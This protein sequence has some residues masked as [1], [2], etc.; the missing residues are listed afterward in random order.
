MIRLQFWRLWSIPS[1]QLF[2]LLLWPE[3]VIVYGSKQR[4]IGLCAKKKLLRNNYTKNVNMNVQRT[5]FIVA[6][7]VSM[8]RP[9]ACSICSIFPL[10]VE[11]NTLKKS[12]NKS[13]VSRFLHEFLV[14]IDGLSESVMFWISFSTSYFDSF[15]EFSQQS[16]INLSSYIYI[17]I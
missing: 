11:S 5:R 3:E 15:E 7:T 1:L 6:V 4:S 13:V 14:W 12:M 16:I 2:L 8:G 9:Y 10:C 17:Y